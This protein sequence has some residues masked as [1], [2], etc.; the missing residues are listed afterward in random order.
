MMHRLLICGLAALAL[1]ACQ[2]KADEPLAELSGRVF[3]FNYRVAAAN[4][5]IT[6]RKTAPFPEGAYA[7]AEFENPQ[8]G[9]P[10]TARQKLFPAMEKIVLE[11][12]DLKCVKKDKTYSVK[13]RLVGAD[14]KPLQTIETSVTSNMEQTE[15]MPS[16]PLV[17]GPIYTPNPEVFKADGS[18]DYAKEANCPA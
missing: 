2:R 12:P 15:M 17:V 13:I 10:L 8:G 7:E 16:K 18:V 9:A 3:I 1:A 6:L 5:V 11:S 4:Y 14:R